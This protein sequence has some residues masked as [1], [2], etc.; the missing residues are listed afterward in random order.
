[1]MPKLKMLLILCLAALP[2][3][4][5]EPRVS[6]QNAIRQ[7]ERPIEMLGD[8]YPRK[9]VD[10]YGHFGAWE[11]TA[12]FIDEYGV[13]PTTLGVSIEV[14]PLL[15][16]IYMGM[17]ERHLHLEYEMAQVSAC[18]ALL[19]IANGSTDTAA[20]A[21]ADG[22]GTLADVENEA[23]RLRYFMF[24]IEA[25]AE[26]QLKHYLDSLDIT[27]RL[28]PQEVIGR[29]AALDV[30]PTRPNRILELTHHADEAAIYARDASITCA[31]A[32]GKQRV[33][34]AVEILTAQRD[35]CE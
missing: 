27:S 7:A 28:R 3:L 33:K 35:A 9:P 25:Y 13:R 34:V 16:N 31:P 1:M 26:Y 14:P 5:S 29:F 6:D 10:G 23:T 32:G 11:S 12:L 22:C 4:A 8:G 24:A 19:I 30:Y 15:L 2:A 20:Y 21:A 17:I 18:A